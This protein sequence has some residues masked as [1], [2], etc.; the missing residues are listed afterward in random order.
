ME[1]TLSPAGLQALADAVRAGQAAPIINFGEIVDPLLERKA[2]NL[3]VI[4]INVGLL[5]APG[6]LLPARDTPYIMF[7]FAILYQYT[8]HSV[9]IRAGG[10]TAFCIR[11]PGTIHTPL[12]FGNI[13]GPGYTLPA[14]GE[15]IIFGLTGAPGRTTVIMAYS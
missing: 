8:A 1:V 11:S 5:A 4:T 15:V 14:A 10:Q 13:Y 6:V 12:P 9:E 2:E 7:Y 3:K